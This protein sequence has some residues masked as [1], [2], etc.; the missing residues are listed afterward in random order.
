MRTIE[1]KVYNFSE[2]SEQ[3]KQKAISGILSIGMTSEFVWDDIKH[4]AKEIGLKITSLS[5]RRGNE[6][7]FMLGAN[8][9]AQNIFNNHGEM[10]DTYKT[11]QKFMEEFQPIFDNYMDESHPDFESSESEDKLIEIENEFLDSLL[12]DYRIMYNKDIEYSESDEAIIESI[13]ANDYEFT[14]DGEQIK[15]LKTRNNANI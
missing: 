13:N 6:G 7:E 15:K 14:E 4:D 12:E 2:L 11:A 3:A 8:E 9:V 1:T 5:D 10:C